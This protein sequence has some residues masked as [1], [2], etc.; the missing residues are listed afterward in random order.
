[1]KLPFILSILFSFIFI[2]CGGDDSAEQLNAY[3]AEAF[4]YDIGGGSWEVNASSRVKGFQQ[5]EENS[6]FS[7]HLSYT[8]D[9]VKT[10]GDTVKNLYEGEIKKTE[11]ESFMDVPLEA[12]FELDSLYIP[13]E[14]EIIFRVKDELTGKT[15]T[16]TAK[17]KLSS[18]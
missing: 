7:I 5:K 1:M 4:A 10:A 17:F 3:N 9:M 16:S 15:S 14:Y 12:Q 6:K 11:Y 8:A 18:D 13:G 2:S